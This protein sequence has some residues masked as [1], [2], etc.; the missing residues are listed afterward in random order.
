VSMQADGEETESLLCLSPLQAM[1]MQREGNISFLHRNIIY[2][3]ILRR[4]VISIS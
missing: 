2:S 4:I 1:D 3:M